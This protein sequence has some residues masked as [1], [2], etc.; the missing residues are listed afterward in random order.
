MPEIG[1]IMPYIY[2]TIYRTL[3]ATTGRVPLGT[4]RGPHGRSS[5]A[6]PAPAAA[7]GTKA[8]GRGRALSHRGGRTGAGVPL[9]QG[10]ALG[11]AVKGEIR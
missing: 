6:L 2:N 8:V 10:G 5:A 3:Q 1:H 11:K 9:H 7:R 4:L